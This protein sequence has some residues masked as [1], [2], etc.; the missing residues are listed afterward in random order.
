[1]AWGGFTAAAA[2][3]EAAPD[4]E[5]ERDSRRARAYEWLDAG[6]AQPSADAFA[7][8][9]SEDGTDV[10]S[11]VGRIRSLLRLQ[12]RRE[13]LEEARGHAAARPASAALA[14]ALGEA[15]YRAGRLQEIEA[16]IAELASGDDAPGR[17]L[18]TLGRLRLAQGREGEAVD[19]MARAVE[20]GPTERDVFYWASGASATRGEAVTRLERY[21]ELAEGDDPDRIEAARTGVEVLRALGERAVWVNQAR[22]ES[23]EIPLT[24]IWDPETRITQGFVIG[25]RLGERKKPVPLM[26]DTGS[27]GLF[28][29]A[30]AARKCAFAPLAEQ[31]QF[32]GGGSGRH[33][34]T[35]GLFPTAAFGELRFGEALASSN[36]QEMDPTGRYHGVIGLAAF[37]GYRV[38]L[39]LEKDRLLLEPPGETAEGEPYWTVEGQWLVEAGLAG[40]TGLFL[41]DTGATH[42]FVDVTTVERIP[43]AQVGTP[44]A[45]HGFGGRIAGARQV[46]QVEVAFQ[47]QTTGS[48]PLNAIDLS[49]RSRLGGV[50]LAGFIGLDLLDGKLLVI[51]TVHRRVSV[52]DPE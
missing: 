28:V 6:E 20:A 44:V 8:L 25:A 36:R 10:A 46:R 40:E 22:P 2:P 26:L 4:A 16:A 41:L 30:R 51:D 23:A 11:A 27:P 29:I 42:T 43:G 18:A 9:L 49:A 24:R 34:T 45:V 14:E 38:T 13:A 15:L 17:A 35:R 5:A 52:R 37:N 48:G 50:E 33:R 47:G 1:V 7:E 31:S 12:R 19:L 3:P 21:L 39:D 32:G